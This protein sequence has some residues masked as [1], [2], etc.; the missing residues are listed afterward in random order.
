[1]HL[2]F[3][4]LSFLLLVFC[5]DD[6]EY[7]ATWNYVAFVFIRLII[8][9][10]HCYIYSSKLASRNNIDLFNIHFATI[11]LKILSVFLV[12]FSLSS[13]KSLYFIT[14]NISPLRNLI[15]L[16]TLHLVT[17]SLKISFVLLVLLSTKSLYFI[18]ASI[19]LSHTLKAFSSVWI[20]CNFIKCL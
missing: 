4:I 17:I 2:F 9:I 16:F 20:C 8:K 6:L 1:M 19:S 14:I 5:M 15:D 12:S 11:V 18:A 10:Y 3:Q 7:M 13:K